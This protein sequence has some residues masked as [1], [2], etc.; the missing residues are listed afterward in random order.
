[1]GYTQMKHNLENAKESAYILCAA[2]IIV[3]MIIIL[4]VLYFYVIKQKRQIAILRALCTSK[5]QCYLFI[6][7][8]LV[9]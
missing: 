1:M 2:G 5:R 7:S 6:L 8:G 3:T 4:M 9:L